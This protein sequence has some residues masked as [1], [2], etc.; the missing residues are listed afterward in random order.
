ML[1]MSRA[2]ISTLDPTCATVPP[3]K[4]K[5]KIRFVVSILILCPKRNRCYSERIIVSIRSSVVIAS[6]A[7]QSHEIATPTCRNFIRLVC[8]NQA[9]PR[10]GTSL[11]LLTMALFLSKAI[12]FTLRLMSVEVPF[13]I[14]TYC[15]LIK[16]CLTKEII[17]DK[18]EHNSL[19]D[20][21]C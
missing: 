3:S 19:I 2:R 17:K 16:K 5:E 8:S 21:L 10:A 20:A 4:E 12:Y 1:H 11:T 18:N 6:V 7:K 14:L 15:N 13:I 9:L